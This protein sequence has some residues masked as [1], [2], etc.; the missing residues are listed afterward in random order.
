MTTAVAFFRGIRFAWPVSQVKL[1][2][3]ASARRK[4]VDRLEPDGLGAIGAGVEVLKI[5]HNRRSRY[6]LDTPRD[7]LQ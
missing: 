5:K 6:R 1:A 3:S 7:T 4:C 2:T